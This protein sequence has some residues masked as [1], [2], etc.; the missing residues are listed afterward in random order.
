MLQLSSYQNAHKNDVIHFIGI[1]G[2]G[3]SAI[4]E[5]MHHLGYKIQGSDIAE[6]AN[7]KR[8]SDIG[9][10]IYIEHSID[11]IS[12]YVEYIVCSTAIDN[13]NIEVLEAKKRKI[14]ILK[15]A[16]VL[17]ELM[18]F[19]TS[20]AVS[21]SHGKTTTTSLIAGIFEEAGCNPTVING[22]IINN[23]M[24]NAYLGQ[25]EYLIAEADESDET[26]VN[27]PATIAVITNISPE[28]LDYYASFENVLKAFERFVL[29]LPFYGF[30]V[31]CSDN[32][33]CKNLSQKI[34]NRKIITYGIDDKQANVQGFNINCSNS[35]STFD[36][37]I[38]LPGQNGNTIIENITLPVPGMHNILNSL[39]AIAIGAKMNF[40]ITTI[41]KG[42]EKFKGV[43][44]RFTKV[45]EYNQ[46]IIIDDYAHHPEEI[47]A[48][49]KTAKLFSNGKGNKII[50]FFQPHRY[51]RFENL[52]Q[53]FLQIF[54]P[55]EYLFTLPVYAAGEKEIAGVS[56]EKFI[57]D[58]K[59]DNAY[60][61]DDVKSIESI[62]KKHAKPFDVILFL[63][64]GNISYLANNLKL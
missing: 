38:C 4:A 57:Q 19:K 63:G 44:R 52:Y 22:G 49:I 41:R 50:V 40:G 21:G 28:H 12:N 53:D 42:F 55:V 16:E 48:V 33:Y 7:T 13:N 15:R 46:A 24:T 61:V 23:K 54:N 37:K 2:I 56:S 26:F 20:I 43:Q 14:P 10:K 60:Y 29:N 9:V 18:R 3:M 64:A 5:I 36:V 6:N 47:K 35:K 58:I 34:A 59:H 8:L 25:N 30:A 45:C 32:I 31:V 11:N 39:A 51:S 17:A 27:I 62:I 1:G